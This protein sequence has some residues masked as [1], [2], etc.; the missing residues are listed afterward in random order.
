MD[1]QQP[2]QGD[3]QG[4]GAG[5]A[6]QQAGGSHCGIIV[7]SAVDGRIVDWLVAT[8]GP[9]AI[10]R[11]VASLPGRRRPYPSSVVRALGLVVP[12]EVQAEPP[13]PPEQ[14]RAQLQQLRQILRAAGVPR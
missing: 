1:G 9:V 7:E 3:Q 2:G 13:T 14:A 8:V 12:P 6:G 10:E 5:P 11:A 4:P